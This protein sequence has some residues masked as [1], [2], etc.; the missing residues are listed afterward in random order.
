M[1]KQIGQSIR[2][3]GAFIAN[4][5]GKTGLTVTVDVLKNG[6][7]IVTAGAASESAG[8]VYSYTLA[9]SSV[10]AAGNY[11]AIF[12]TSDTSVDQQHVFA[13][14]DVGTNWVER[15]NENVNAAKT[16]TVAE[17]TAIRDAGFATGDA[18]ARLGAAGAGLTA[19]GDA[20]LANLDSPIST[21]S[22]HSVADVVAAVWNA[23]TRTLSAFGFTVN[24]NANATETAIKA[25]TDALPA[26]PA[27]EGNVS[28]VG[29]AVIAL[30]TPLQTSNYSAPPTVAAIRIELDANSS[31]L[32]NLDAAISSRS[33]FAG[34]A[35]A[36]VA[37]PVTVGTNQ[38]KT[39]YDLSAAARTA[40]ANEVEAQIIDESDSEKV[41]TAIV[42]KIAAVN[43]SFEELSL[44][45][46]A[47]ASRSE[48]ERAGGMLAGVKTR[49]DSLPAN[50][51][52]TGDIPTTAQN[53]SAARAEL[54]VELA[55][56]DAPV[57]SR[58]VPSDV[59]LS[60]GFETGDR[61][62]LTQRATLA[63]LQNALGDLAI[64]SPQDIWG[65]GERTLTQNVGDASA[66]QQTMIL[67]AIQLL[68]AASGAGGAGAVLE[69]LELV[70]IAVLGRVRFLDQ[71]IVNLPDA[72]A[73][74]LVGVTTAH[75][76][77]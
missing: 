28:A 68:T 7:A 35:V 12:K 23:T 66:E 73:Q 57:S 17:R 37:D 8:G 31:K 4:K 41:L 40:L 49:A 30:G 13:F 59:E 56:M 51:A 9:A 34:G 60:G 44:S 64:P 38:D 54:A 18:F 62:A 74:K 76:E 25:K 29:N 50:P 75:I 42:D 55:R 53:A 15:I 72:T 46:I 63:Q 77:L 14:F 65:F 19:I 58:A 26:S 39:G 22:N 10:D 27:S 36:S 33:T 24:T 2:F 3:P 45:A 6:V 20:R 11:I 70:R 61:D 16:L 47:A 71:K 21:R 32:A 1:M 5:V 52:A 43:P 48:I 67:N 69:A